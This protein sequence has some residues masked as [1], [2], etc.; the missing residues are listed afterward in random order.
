M[1]YVQ[2]AIVRLLAVVC[3]DDVLGCV[4]VVEHDLGNDGRVIDEQAARDKACCVWV[5][6]EHGADVFGCCAMCKVLR[7]NYVIA[8]L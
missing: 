3:L 7:N 2:H 1:V 5:G 4:L 8:W 6:C